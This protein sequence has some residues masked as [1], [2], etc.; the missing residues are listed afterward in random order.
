MSKIDTSNW[1][2]FHLYDIFEISMGNKF[3]KNKMKQL[4]PKINFV[5]RG[6]VNNGVVCEVD[7]VYDKMT[8]LLYHIKKVI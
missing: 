7:I 1:G 4:N 3:D 5:G 2:E 8:T 6:S